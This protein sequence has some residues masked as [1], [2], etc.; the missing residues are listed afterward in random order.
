[1]TDVDSTLE[2]DVGI[3]GTED[4]SGVSQVFSNETV[5]MFTTTNT[6]L[7]SC[8]SLSVNVSASS[9]I[10]ANIS[11][12]L[13]AGTITVQNISSS[14]YRVNLTSEW[15]DGILFE[16]VSF[17][18]CYL[19]GNGGPINVRGFRGASLHTTSNDTISISDGT[20]QSL[21]IMA[22]DSDVTVQR[23]STQNLMV[24]G[25]DATLYV[26][27]RVT[28]PT[29][30]SQDCRVNITSERGSILLT[31][32]IYSNKSCAIIAE[33]QTGDFTGSFVGFQGFYIVVMNIDQADL[34]NT[35]CDSNS[36]SATKT[37]VGQVRT[38]LDNGNQNSG[39]TPI[40]EHSLYLM[41][42]NGLVTLVFS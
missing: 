11:M 19:F 2:I 27:V 14:F 24:N 30:S 23:I 17:Y 41:I 34:P 8:E 5:I 3:Y 40:V 15:N 13:H 16:N 22:E 36:T 39:S 18:K 32:S 9:D 6:T 4:P 38:S 25:Q 10:I 35:S 26:G 12:I 21:T 33:S 42:Y 31:A 20:L 7:D 37:C 1:M 28:E 29:Q